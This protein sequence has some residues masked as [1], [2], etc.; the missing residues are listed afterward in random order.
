MLSI[1]WMGS[2]WKPISPHTLSFLNLHLQGLISKPSTIQKELKIELRLWNNY[3]LRNANGVNTLCYHPLTYLFCITYYPF[4]SQWLHLSQY[5]MVL[6][7]YASYVW[8]WEGGYCCHLYYCNYSPFFKI[9]TPN[10][11]MIR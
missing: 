8:G 5:L 4:F 10:Y 11:I 2:T 1:S 7:F 6:S 3:C 9:K